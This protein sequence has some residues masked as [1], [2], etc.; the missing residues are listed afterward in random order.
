MKGP[1]TDILDRG[2]KQ[3]NLHSGKPPSPETD[4]LDRGLKLFPIHPHIDVGIYPETD[5]LDR[6]R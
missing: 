6:S 4:I 2:L 1:E 3:L 5:I